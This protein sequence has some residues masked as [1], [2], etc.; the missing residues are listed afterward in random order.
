MPPICFGGAYLTVSKLVSEVGFG[1]LCGRAIQR[2]LGG[3]R[4]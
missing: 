3:L 4:V 1:L 2:G